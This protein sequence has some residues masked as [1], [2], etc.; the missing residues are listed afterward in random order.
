MA[1][2]QINRPLLENEIIEAQDRSRSASEAA[3]Y[4]RVSY[5]TYKKYADMY[6]IHHRLK[7]Q[8]GAGIQKAR[9]TEN[10]GTPLRDILDGKKP[11]YKPWMVKK[12]LINSGYKD[13]KCEVCGFDERRLIDDKSPLK[14]HY[15][16]GDR[17]NH[18]FENLQMICYNCYYLTVGN[19]QGRTKTYFMG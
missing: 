16:D 13:Q 6:G 1:R 2:T 8:A 10:Q 19:T 11:K 12:R 3:R 9:T 17:T 7:N 15:I 4:L 18:R 14:L 5:K